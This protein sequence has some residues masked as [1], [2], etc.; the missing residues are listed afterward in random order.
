MKL[1]SVALLL[2]VSLFAAAQDLDPLGS[3]LPASHTLASL[4]EDLV[5]I[6]PQISG[7]T[8]GSL[9]GFSAGMALKNYDEFAQQDLIDRE[10]LIEIIQTYWVNAQELASS[11]SMIKVYRLGHDPFTPQKPMKA[12]DLLFRLAYVKRDA[13][14]SFTVRPD[15]APKR[16]R[17]SIA[18]R[19][20]DSTSGG[21]GASSAAT[22]LA[23]IKQLGIGLSILAVDYD[24]NLPYVES[25]AH[26]YKIAEPYL[27][28]LQLTKSLNPSGGRLLFNISLAGVNTFSIEEPS[29]TPLVYD[30]KPWPD[31]RRLVFFADGSAK[32][33]SA[34]EWGM[35]VPNLK[36][37]LPRK[38]KPLKPGQMPDGMK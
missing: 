18:K 19:G 21:N 8:V 13:I 17:E 32:F 6:Q 20:S 14:V 16:I 28:N 23:N 22:A 2:T 24:D 36:L 1:L 15:L 35:V 33:L 12:P 31:G 25:T 4:S 29:E 3:G 37:N 27:K 11:S 38:G 7:D 10:L 5:A 30:E 34:L 26:L 9:M